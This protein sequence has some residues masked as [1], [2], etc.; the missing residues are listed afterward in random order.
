MSTGSNPEVSGDSSAP[1]GTPDAFVEHIEERYKE[2]EREFG[3]E[4]NARRTASFDPK[5]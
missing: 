4:I 1:E 5:K 2:W 3:D